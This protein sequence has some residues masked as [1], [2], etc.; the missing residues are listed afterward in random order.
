MWEWD[1]PK[2]FLS[3]HKLH[4]KTTPTKYTLDLGQWQLRVEPD[5]SFELPYHK[6]VPWSVNSGLVKQ[7][8]GGGCCIVVRHCLG[9]LYV[10]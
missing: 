5:K 7:A 8:K 6:S 2:N 3:G 9:G 1:N 10:I 4:P